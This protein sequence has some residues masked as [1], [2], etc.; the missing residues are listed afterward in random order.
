MKLTP[1]SFF[2]VYLMMGILFTYV[3]IQNAQGTVWNFMTI[4]LAAFATFDFGVSI[5]M[6][7]LHFKIKKQKK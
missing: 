1:K 3:A 7:R 2:F 5:R 4:L 6:L